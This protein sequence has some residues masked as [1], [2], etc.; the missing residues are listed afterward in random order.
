MNPVV[1]DGPARQ[2]STD[3]RPVAPEE[4]LGAFVIADPDAAKR[5]GVD[6]PERL[7]RSCCGATACG[8]DRPTS[9]SCWRV[10]IVMCA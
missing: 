1:P 6:G 4:I 8:S 3:V 5:E 10:S 2:W 7:S 9:A